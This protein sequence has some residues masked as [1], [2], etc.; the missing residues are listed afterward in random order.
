MNNSCTRALC[1]TTAL[2]LILA[3]VPLAARAQASGQPAKA[4]ASDQPVEAI[5][6]TARR[7]EERLQDV[8]MSITVL[9]QSQ[10]TDNNI[11]SAGDLATYVPALSVNTQFGS[12][13]TSFVIRGFSQ[14]IG[15]SPTVGTYFADVV[16]PRGGFGGTT[17]HA[18]EG[19]GPGAFFDLANVDVL[20]GP[21]GTLFGRNTTGGAIQLVP[22]K[23][24]GR[25]EGYV[26]VSGGDY[27]ML[28]LQGV[29]NVPVNDNLRIRLGVDHQT[30]DGYLTNLS[31]TGPATFNN[32]DY[33]AVRLSVVADLAPNLENYTIASLTDSRNN[34]SDVQIVACNPAMGLGF[35]ACAQM[36]SDAS[37]TGPYTVDNSVFNAESS[38]KEWQVI[39][40]TTWTANDNVTVKNIF[41]YSQ[42][43][44]INNSS[45]FGD[46]FN[47][48][49]FPLFFTAEDTP[50]GTLLSDQQSVTEE[51]RVQGRA[52]DGRLQWQAGLYYEMSF[53]IALAGSAGPNAIS[54]TNFQ[55]LR[56]FDLFALLEGLP[57]GTIG[58][59]GRRY[60]SVTWRDYGAYAQDTYAITNQLKLTTGIRYSDD[61][62]SATTTRYSYY[63]PAPDTP[64]RAC[65]P[66]LAANGSCV[67]NDHQ[68]SSAPT[69]LVNL[70]YE[71]NR[72]L[73]TYIQYARGYRQGGILST[74]PIGYT[75]FKPEQLNA[76]ELGL[77]ATLKGPISGFVN[78]AVF[79]N[80][81]TD[82]QIL[83]TFV[84]TTP[85]IP[86][87]AGI[88]NAGSSRIFGLD[89]DSSINLTH[90]LT[91]ALAY[92]YLNSKLVKVNPEQVSGFYN[93]F[94]PNEPQGSQLAL[95]PESKLS[96]TTTYRLPVDRSLGRMSVSLTYL[97]TST[98]LVYGT[99]P[100]SH[101]PATNLLN[102]AAN[103][104][105]VL[106]KP[107]DLEFFMTNVGDLH[108]PT[109]VDNFIS[110]SSQYAQYGFASESF[111][112][113]RMFGGRL[114]YHF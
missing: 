14:D 36:K 72:N 15:T 80:D 97:Y 76:F 23:P 25:Y 90:E 34:G 107:V 7:V 17:I 108:Y 102:L 56:C 49:G 103:W 5:V 96:L 59:D 64:V 37:R 6:V 43:R 78:G 61:T 10:L 110:A 69:G 39:N 111:G 45:L 53:P 88:L 26:E 70:Q 30:R 16:E 106:G 35:F 50:P 75:T 11:S 57:Q 12:D 31:A 4:A 2:G 77:K 104:E 93:V 85:G 13:A 40:T 42:I 86:P 65:E 9:R 91:V 44:V 3:A 112:P 67:V 28:R 73:Q 84:S 60:G 29:I 87:N 48:A 1:V 21:Q 68:K 83:G 94:G 8:P 38:I 109:Y 95:T 81:F 27:D 58:T 54:C 20:K 33:T 113:P 63:F 19:A 47:V 51:P 74:G 89:L 98:E 62:T 66:P 24:T 18:G 82:Q 92:T 105:S 32:V 101:L 46:N 79:Y 100:Y 99:G 114:R 52:L 41:S 22:Q 71:W 55:Q